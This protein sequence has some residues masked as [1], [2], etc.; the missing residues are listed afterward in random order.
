MVSYVYA[1]IKSFQRIVGLR[2]ENEPAEDYET[3]EHL[4]PR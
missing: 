2:K 4:K 1:D 3:Q